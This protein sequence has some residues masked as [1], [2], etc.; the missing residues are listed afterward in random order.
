M[1]TEI[2]QF[3]VEFDK[4]GRIFSNPQVDAVLNAVGG[5]TDL[6]VFSHGWNNDMAD[7][8]RLY[9]N[10]FQKVKEVLDAGVVPG[11]DGRKYAAVGVFWPSKKFADEELIPAGGSASATGE[12]AAALN[13]LLEELKNDPDRLGGETHDPQRDQ[14]LDKA[15]ALVPRLE[16]DAAARKDFVDLLRSI[17]NSKDAHAEDGS[18]E[19]F[20]L[21]AQEMFDELEQPVVAPIGNRAGGAT[22]VVGAGAGAGAGGGGGGAAGLKDMIS[23]AIGAARRIAN[24][25]T[26]YQMKERAGVVG[27]DGVCQMLRKIRQKNGD[28]RLHLIGHSFGGR[29]VTAAADALDANTAKVT[30][31]LLQAAYSHNGLAEKFDGKNNGFFRKLVTEKRASGPIVITHTKNDTAVGIAYPLASKL[32]R[33]KSAALGDENDPYG[34][35]GRNGAQRTAEAKGLGETIHPLDQ[36]Y[37]FSPGKIYNLKA[38]DVIGDHSDIC[39]HECAFAMLFAAAAV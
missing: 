10:F 25:T 23:G 4:K 6:F 35:M 17:V 28:I 13:A 27:R 26:Y 30:I 3:E 29:V 36:P 2:P 19:F 33:D 7:A 1:A 32:S 18:D 31:T 12:N 5:V 14:K 20:T 8:R 21:P 34:G 24:F 39:K 16:N 9:Q 11:L 22:G 37:T 38:D 15:K